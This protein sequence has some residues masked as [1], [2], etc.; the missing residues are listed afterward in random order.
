M[1][2]GMW[3][4]RLTSSRTRSALEMAARFNEARHEVLAENLANIDTPDYATRQLDPKRFQASL[5]E[6][7][8]R[9]ENRNRT[10]LNLRGNA[11]FQHDAHGVL[12]SRPETRPAQNIQFHDGTNASI[13]TIMNDVMANSLE[14]QLNVNLLRDSY[15][16]LLNAIRGRS[17]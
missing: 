13:E 8:D 6:A 2:G 9:A 17:T 10:T 5:R 14:Y 16:S 12:R 4:E 1:D 7:L 3:I 11:Q 15:G